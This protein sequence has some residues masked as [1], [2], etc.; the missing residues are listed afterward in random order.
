MPQTARLPLAND[1]SPGGLVDDSDA[2]QTVAAGQQGTVH[3]CG[4][5]CGPICGA[6]GKPLGQ[7]VDN[8]PLAVDNRADDFGLA[9]GVY[10]P[11]PSSTGCG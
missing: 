11:T 1:P 8:R 9:P 3:P 5:N 6:L 2:S 10:L 4:R 7:P